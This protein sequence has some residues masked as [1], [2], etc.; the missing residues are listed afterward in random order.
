[1][2]PLA[3]RLALKATVLYIFLFAFFRPPL[4]LFVAGSIFGRRL[5]DVAFLAPSPLAATLSSAPT[6]LPPFRRLPAHP[7]CADRHRRLL[8]CCAGGAPSVTVL[9][10]LFKPAPLSP[11][12]RGFLF[13]ARLH[14]LR[15]RGLSCRGPR[16][17][18]ALAWPPCRPCAAVIIHI[19]G[20]YPTPSSRVWA[21]DSRTRNPS[22]S[23][24]HDFQPVGRSAPR[25]LRRAAAAY[26]VGYMADSTPSL[27][28]PLTKR[29]VASQFDAGL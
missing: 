10:A 27:L 18:F 29:D 8:F 20:F 9:R 7:R 6:P 17:C 13:P 5:A 25:A 23:V 19:R 28:C 4:F 2:S 3:P 16:R 1:M 26:G 11:P 24:T 22:T 14:P 21:C 15:G 12:F